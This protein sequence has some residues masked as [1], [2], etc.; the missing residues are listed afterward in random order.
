MAVEM[1]GRTILSTGIA[2]VGMGC[3]LP[4]APDP[5]TFWDVLRS[6]TETIADAPADRWDPVADAEV[7]G[8]ID[9]ESEAHDLIM[10]VFAGMS[11]GERSRIKIRVRSAMA[12]QTQLEGRYRGGDLGSCGHE[13]RRRGCSRS[14]RRRRRRS[15]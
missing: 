10:S 7:G 5:T 2:V 15:R 3:R 14:A 13:V 12:A 11:K 9:P 4:G 6:G 1:T 8:A